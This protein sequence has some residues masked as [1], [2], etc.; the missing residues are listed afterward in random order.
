M[1][2]GPV[3]PFVAHDAHDAPASHV[4]QDAAHRQACR[5]LSAA[6]LLSPEIQ[7]DPPTPCLSPAPLPRLPPHLACRGCRWPPGLEDDQVW[8]REGVGQLSPVAVQKRVQ[9]TGFVDTDQGGQVLGLVQLRGVGLWTITECPVASQAPTPP[10]LHA[11]LCSPTRSLAAPSVESRVPQARQTAR[12]LQR[13]SHS[14]T[15]GTGHPSPSPVVRP[16]SHP[17]VHTGPSF[18]RSL[19]C[20]G[21]CS[22]QRCGKVSV[23]CISNPPKT[24][25]VPKSGSVL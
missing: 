12:A 14:P 17:S 4:W 24:G 7:R 10:P 20:E 9:D 13:G 2:R 19:Y 15:R 16:G 21:R 11:A 25:G 3:W 8:P 6:V 5:G 23:S 1:S 22:E 18:L